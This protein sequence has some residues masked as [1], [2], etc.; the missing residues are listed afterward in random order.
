MY[1]IKTRLTCNWDPYESQEHEDRLLNDKALS[2]D[3]EGEAR[4]DGIRVRDQNER[5]KLF[6]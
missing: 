2:Q 1:Y 5:K 6:S 3:E 4:Q